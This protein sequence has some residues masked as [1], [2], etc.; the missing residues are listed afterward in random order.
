MYH[1]TL[2]KIMEHTLQRIE[3]IAPTADGTRVSASEPLRW[4]SLG[5]QDMRRSPVA[6]LSYGVI[7]AAIGFLILNIASGKP[8]LLLGATSGFFLLAPLLAAGLYELSRRH[9]VGD[10]ATFRDSFGGWRRNGQSLA[11]FGFVL[12]FITLCWE[13]VSAQLFALSYRGEHIAEVTNFVSSMLLSG[14]NTQFMVTYSVVGGIVAAVVFALAA[15]TVP[16]LVD[17]EVDVVTAMHASLKAVASN[18]GAMI[19]WAGLIVALVA[20]GYATMMIGIVLVM[21]LLGHATWHAY[22]ALVK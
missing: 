22:K 9:A 12:T 11:D 19:V 13:M 7:F 16:M 8:Y 10:L 2:E 14:T 21:P 4:L 1:L 5:W 17:R 3:R 15:V 18:P 20:V 6:S